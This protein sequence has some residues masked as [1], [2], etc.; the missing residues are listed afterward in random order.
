MTQPTTEAS[1]PNPLLALID[2]VIWTATLNGRTLLYANSALERVYG[3]PIADFLD[4]RDLWLEMVHPDD[5]AAAA[6]SAHNLL[7]QSHTEATYRIVRPDG[8]VRW[9]RD[10]QY[11]IYDK[12]GQPQHIGGIARDITAQKQTEA[13][14]AQNQQ[15][16]TA[17]FS[18]ALDAIFFMMLDEPVVWNEGVDKETVLDYAFAHQRVTRV[19]PA[20]LAQYRATPEQ[21]IGKTP[22][23]LFKPAIKESRAVW[24]QLFDQGQ[25]RTETNV[26]RFDGTAM[27]IE[28]DYI[29]LYDDAGRITGQVCVQRDVTER[30][31]TEETLREIRDRLQ[32]AESVAHFGNWELDL[33]ERK[34]HGSA[35]AR[36]I[37]GLA[38]DEWPLAVVQGVPLPEYRPLL[39]AALEG[40]IEHNQP[41]NVEFR[42][43]RL[44]DGELRDIHSI[45]EYDPDRRVIFG[46]IH[47]ITER[48]LAEE[49]LRESEKRFRMVLQDVPAVAVQGYGMDGTT[50]YWNKASEFLYGYTAEEALGRNLLDLIIPPEMQA[51][52]RQGIRQMSE[53]GQ[54]LP[55]SDLSLRRKDG[56]RVSVYS[57]HALVQRPY[58]ELELFCI[59]IDLTRQKQTEAALRKSK[60]QYDKLVSKIPVGVYIIHSQP[61]GAFDFAY[62][63]PKL[64][65]M[66]D[67]KVEDF[68][69]DP[70]VCFQLIH[71]DDLEAFVILNQKR[72]QQL[73]P[74]EW[75]GRAVIRETTRWLR[76]EST[77]EPLENGDTL[78]HGMVTDITDR[79]LAEAARNQLE[80][81]QRQLQKA[82]SLGRMAGAVAHHF[83]N[84]LQGVIGYIE[85][86]MLKLPEHSSSG[87]NLRQALAAAEQSVE[88][89]RMML[90]YLGQTTDALE[91]LDLAETCTK[92]LTSLRKTLP[93]GVALNIDV[94]S[95]GPV[96]TGNTPR[97]RQ[98]LTQLVTNAWEAMGNGPG[99]ID[100]TIT[101]VSAANIPAT[102]RF[103]LE[104]QPRE[105]AYACLAISDTGSG[106]AA[107]DI[108][109]LFDPFFST[110]F[111]GRGLGLAIVMGIIR[112]H[113]GAVTVDSSPGQGSTFRFFFPLTPQVSTRLPEPVTA[114]SKKAK[115]ATILLVDDDK[116]VNEMVAEMLVHLGFT[117]VVAEGG[118]KAVE[119]FRQRQ[120]EI[121]CVL[122]DINMPGMDGW[123]TLAALRQL[124]P[125]IPVILSS[126]YD[127]AEVMVA[128]HHKRPQAFLSKPYQMS[129]IDQ[130]IRRVMDS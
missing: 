60:E 2:E 119:L 6:Q 65:E 107:S 49:A 34:F 33:V 62:V 75:E 56:S 31:Q 20:L 98:L 40:L 130:V 39:D 82:E 30:K 51:E 14:L 111:T 101:T 41:Y 87:P 54:P 90:V 123:E 92:S 124:S 11:L 103:P 15:L 79:K 102:A 23:D 72:L 88:M 24:R 76:I 66:F 7:E 42:I 43:R 94:P 126:G 10:R 122:C 99:V 100:L 112:S 5:R 63:S 29:C 73:Q 106:I 3:R 77:P 70:Q 96:I 97:L 95:P 18:Q 4:N 13:D 44:D 108:E 81:Q 113:S 38:G 109:K 129:E 118:V 52:V 46:V 115:G 12:T 55:A 48:K 78:W 91:R 21:F 67:L 105:Q 58:Q 121:D 128:Q 47:D 74:F 68:L 59:D 85:I 53:T 104:W 27:M 80:A 64:A 86:A 25:L 120:H 57:S 114:G 19:N 16:L 45:A 69:A 8:E 61:K 32:R 71:P 116:L 1:L 89:S 22:N 83:N 9:I 28:S 37:Y 17:F 93:P 125:D 35:G 110:K 127:E 26:P 84:W 36:T 117:V 50:Q